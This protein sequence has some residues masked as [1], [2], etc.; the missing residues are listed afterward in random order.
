MTDG[1][2]KNVMVSRHITE[3]EGIKS[4][5]RRAEYEDLFRAAV[6]PAYAVAGRN[7]IGKSRGS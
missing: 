1:Y 3:C 7:T 5:Y 2:Q 4:R 6:I